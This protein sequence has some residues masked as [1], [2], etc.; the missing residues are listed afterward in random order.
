MMGIK[1]SPVVLEHHKASLEKLYIPIIQH[2]RSRV[3]DR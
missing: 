3:N 1:K 2:P